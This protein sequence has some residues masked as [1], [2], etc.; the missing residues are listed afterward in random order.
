MTPGK[1]RFTGLGRN[2]AEFEAEIGSDLDVFRA[3]KPHLMSRE[4]DFEYY[5]DRG[6]GEV[7]AGGRCVGTFQMIH[8]AHGASNET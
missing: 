4:I 6:F 1:Y 7:F 5:D 8:R 3:V 2:K